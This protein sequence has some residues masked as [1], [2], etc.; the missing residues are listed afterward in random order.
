[1]GCSLMGTS[2]YGGSWNACSQET[3]RLFMAGHQQVVARLIGVAKLVVFV[4]TMVLVV[5]LAIEAVSGQRV[6]AKVE[7]KA[8]I[9]PKWDQTRFPESS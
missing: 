4:F 9:S 3:F 1:V 2:N 7:V 8:S 5:N 6:G